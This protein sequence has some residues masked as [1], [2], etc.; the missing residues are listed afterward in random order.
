MANSI[1]NIFELAAKNPQRVAFPEAT[2][3]KVLAVVT[4]VAKRGICHPVL[5]GDAEEIKKAAAGFNVD[6][7]KFE[8]ADSTN[9]DFLTPLIKIFC[10]MKPMY[11]EKG[12]RRRSADALYVALMME[13]VGDIDFTFAGFVNKT[14]D[15]LL[16]SQYV[17]GP[18]DENSLISSFGLVN[19]PEKMGDECRFLCIGDC[20]VAVDPTAEELAQIA[21]QACDES[22]ALLG[23]EP[24]CAML[25]Y[26]TFGSGAGAGVDK[27]A[28]AVKIAN[29]KRPDLLIDGEIQL[30]AA[31]NPVVG[32]K[33]SANHPSKVAGNA[34]ILIF[35]NIEAGNIGVKLIQQFAGVDVYIAMLTGFAKPLVDCSRGAPVS[36][37]VGLIALS[38]VRAQNMKA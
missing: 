1:N 36:E 2:D 21:I 27:V 24:K 16:A 26:S 5:V 13:A 15:M 22:K 29:E 12:M 23:W 19:L 9:D 14:S 30:D 25:S 18:K 35:P 28:E 3:E 38:C 33:K 20:A 11:G 32:A 31:I 6:I 17:I 10:E 34:N 4:E 37:M 7:S 8:I